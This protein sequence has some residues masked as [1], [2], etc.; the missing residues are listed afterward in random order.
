MKEKALKDVTNKL[1]PKP[2]KLKPLWARVKAVNGP[3]TRKVSIIN[4]WILNGPQA[5]PSV[6]RLRGV[7][8]N[9]NKEGLLPCNPPNQAQHIDSTDARIIPIRLQVMVLG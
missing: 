1:E 5:S 4:K 7:N 2:T 3:A 6:V 9:M 8:A